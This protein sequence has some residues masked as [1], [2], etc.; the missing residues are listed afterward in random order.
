M[1][2]PEK[3][4]ESAQD[5]KAS[6][7]LPKPFSFQHLD[8]FRIKPLSQLSLN[9]PEK[10]YIANTTSSGKPLGPF[11]SNGLEKINVSNKIFVAKPLASLNSNTPEKF[12]ISNTTLTGKTLTP[13][14]FNTPEK[15]NT[16]HRSNS[17]KSI[18]S[19]N[20]I[21]VRVEKDSSPLKSFVHNEGAK[22]IVSPIPLANESYS[23]FVTPQKCTSSQDKSTPQE[24]QQW[25]EN[26]TPFKSVPT[27][28]EDFMALVSD[29][30]FNMSSQQNKTVT[31][32]V[33]ILPNDPIL[34]HQ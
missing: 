12:H 9:T 25:Q 19:N 31:T 2:F 29:S 30:D 3:N 16:S 20:K 13:L 33:F 14:T 17:S 21:L 6:P 24:L 27:S 28:Q 5:T 4:K 7:G 34:P 22:V 11:N 15:I 10:F 8:T 32:D 26:L 18:F 1:I 23:E